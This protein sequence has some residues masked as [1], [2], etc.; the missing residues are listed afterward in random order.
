MNKQVFAALTLGLASSLALSSTN[1]T[2]CPAG[3]QSCG[4]ANPGSAGADGDDDAQCPLLTA[5]RSCMDAYCKTASNPF[6]TCYKRGFDLTTNGCKCIDFDAQKFCEN[7][8]EN[9]VDASAYDCAA[10]SSGVSSYCVG[11]Q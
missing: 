11:V 2:T 3:Q 1:C 8:E 4:N 10:A 6:C 5:M 9:G 7:A